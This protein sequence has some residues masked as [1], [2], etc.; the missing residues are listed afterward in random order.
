[1]NLHKPVRIGTFTT[2]GNLFLAPVAGYSDAAY[3]SVCIDA[4][5]DL[6]FTEMVSSEALTRD[7]A[8]TEALLGR[9]EN[10]TEYAVQ[11]FGANPDVMARAAELTARRWSPALIDVNCGC[12]VPKIT[13]NGAGSALMKEPG[14]IRDIVRAMTAA[15][16]TPV[17]VK[18]RLGWDDD[19]VNYLDAAA[20]AVEGGAAAVT[21]HARTRAQGYSGKADR[22]AFARLA[23][24]V[25]VPVFASGDLHSPA[26][27]IDILSGPAGEARVA[28]VMFARGAM[29]DPF[30][31][32]RTVAAMEGLPE[33]EILGPMRLKAA[34]AHFALSLGFY[35]RHVACVEFRK[36]ACAY[37]RGAP[38]GAE[39]RARAVSCATPDDYEAF[40]GAWEAAISGATGNSSA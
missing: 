20:A 12:P 18:I 30:I 21:L 11:L 3:R 27:A 32:T 9:A 1:M 38:H 26:D 5:C 37:L 24:S 13:R 22:A 4:G 23:A 6:A 28:G 19:S 16:S 31:F 33:P 40:F 2:R 29:G 39:L 35:D 36:Q 25:P 7:S 15:V 14:R 34:R 8:R 10:E 17:T